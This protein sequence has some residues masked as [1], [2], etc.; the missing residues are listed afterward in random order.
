MTPYEAARRWRDLSIAQA[1]RDVE[2]ATFPTTAAGRS[3]N[4]A[5]M[6]SGGRRPDVQPRA[7]IRLL[8]PS[9][10]TANRTLSIADIGRTVEMNVGSAN[11]VTVPSNAEAPFPVGV[12]LLICQV[13]AG[14]TTIT[15]VSGVTVRTSGG[16]AVSARWGEVWLRKRATD[17]WVLSGDV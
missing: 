10:Y 15:P 7:T 4:A 5:P 16:L 6:P 3:K 2:L 17:E 13:G 9:A 12:R 8:A 14:Q 1:R 11:T